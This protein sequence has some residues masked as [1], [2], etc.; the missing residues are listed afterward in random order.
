METIVH[1]VEFFTHRQ[2]VEQCLGP[3]ADQLFE[4]GEAGGCN[5]PVD[6]L[7]LRAV[8]RRIHGDEAADEEVRVLIADD[9]VVDHDAAEVRFGRE[10]LVVLVHGHDVLV[11]R[12]RPEWPVW[13]LGAVVHGRFRPHAL[14]NRQDGLVGEPLRI[15]RIQLLRKVIEYD[16]FTHL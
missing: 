6:R 1:P 9:L 2:R 5:D 10:R 13:A 7:P 15:C 8:L 16:R 3:A 14:E 4:V 12:D 11:A